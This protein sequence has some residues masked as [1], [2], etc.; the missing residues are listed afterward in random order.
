MAGA[1]RHANRICHLR[2]PPLQIQL[3]LP[4]HHS[5]SLSR[6]DHIFLVSGNRAEL[7]IKCEG[8]PGDRL[9]L[10][11]GQRRTAVALWS[12]QLHGHLHGVYAPGAAGGD[13]R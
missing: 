9:K 10:H 13:D 7:L 12:G 5:P 4:C 1:A 3:P 6:V 2:P 11:R 8:E